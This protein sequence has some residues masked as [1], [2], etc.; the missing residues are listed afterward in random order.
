MSQPYVWMCTVLNKNYKRTTHHA[1]CK[2]VCTLQINQ[3]TSKDKLHTHIHKGHLFPTH[4][5]W[6]EALI[7]L[8]GFRE[9]WQKNE[10][11]RAQCLSL[12]CRTS[13]KKLKECSRSASA[14]WLWKKWRRCRQLHWWKHPITELNCPSVSF[15]FNINVQDF[16]SQTKQN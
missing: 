8:W 5:H 10:C 11:K 9:A 3:N 14:K 15:T 2:I 6:L 4:S 7:G 16:F 1:W 12:K 13:Q